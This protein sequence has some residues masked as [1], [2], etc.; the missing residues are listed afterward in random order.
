MQ[1]RRPR[2]TIRRQA[3]HRGCSLGPA[4]AS[5][6]L[7]RRAASR[8]LTVLSMYGSVLIRTIMMTARNT[9]PITACD[10]GDW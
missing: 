8:K 10:S 7:S 2:T 6:H 3:E 5:T 1:S 9:M 4:Y